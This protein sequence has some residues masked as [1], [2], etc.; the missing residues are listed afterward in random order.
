MLATLLPT[1]LTCPPKSDFV[2]ALQLTTAKAAPP[3]RLARPQAPSRLRLKLNCQPPLVPPAL[4]ALKTV[5]PTL[6]NSLSFWQSPLPISRH[7]HRLHPFLQLSKLVAAG[8]KYCAIAL[9]PLQQSQTLQ[10]AT[11]CCTARSTSTSMPH[12]VPLPWTLLLTAMG[13]TH[14]VL[15]FAPLPNPS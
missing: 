13:I 3:S 9:Y 11:T 5:S 15:I 4:H 12:M 10:T 7:L 14:S 8:L 2:R 6:S 1:A